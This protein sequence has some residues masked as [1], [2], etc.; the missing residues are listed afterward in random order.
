MADDN[1]LSIPQGHDA[2][3]ELKESLSQQFGQIPAGPVSNMIDA[4]LDKINAAL[5]AFNQADMASR[6]VDI[7]AAAA[8]MTNPLKDLDG[9]KEEIQTISDDTGKAAQ[10][11]SGVDQ[12]IS[13]NDV[14]LRCQIAL[15]RRVV[16]PK[17]GFSDP[18]K[19]A[20]CPGFAALPKRDSH[21]PPSAQFAQQVQLVAS[22][23]RAPPDWYRETPIC[24][25]AGSIYRGLPSFPEAPL[26][27]LTNPCGAKK[28]GDLMDENG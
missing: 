17:C 27:L 5:T 10:V 18:R 3:Q 12:F 4:R 22:G 15:S 11:L 14:F 6:T 21:F 13:K 9:L 19:Q 23:L 1:N 26:S 7:N 2:L 24:C 16:C 8:A 28:K 25:Q 20:S